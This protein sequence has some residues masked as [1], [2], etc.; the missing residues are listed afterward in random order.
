MGD[1][2]K[3]QPC[4]L[5][6]LTAL[7]Q[8]TQQDHKHNT[9]LTVCFTPRHSPEHNLSS[10]PS[11]LRGVTRSPSRVDRNPNHHTVRGFSLRS[12]KMRI[13]EIQ[14]MRND[15]STV[16]EVASAI[17]CL[18]LSSPVAI[19]L[20]SYRIRYRRQQG[21]RHNCNLI[22]SLINPSP[23]LQSHSIGSIPAALI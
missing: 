14:S 12:D 2:S 16:H 7:P 8:T 11:P 15:R 5:C 4:S 6:F 23:Y 19:F 10:D 18:L 13:T 20:R 22:T 17:V 1:K 9:S 3:S 21:M